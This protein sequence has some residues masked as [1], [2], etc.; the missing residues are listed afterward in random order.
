MTPPL[1]TT[2]LDGLSVRARAIWVG[3]ALVLIVMASLSVSG[4]KTSSQ[5]ILGRGFPDH[6]LYRDINA[7]VGAGKPYYEAVAGEHRKHRYPLKPVFAVRQPTLA[8]VAGH[9]GPFAMQIGMIALIFGA[10]MAW[11]V[12]LEASLR[13]PLAATMSLGIA[14]STA[15]FVVD[16]VI[17]FHESWA[18]IL[19]ALAIAAWRPDRAGWSIGL[20][21]VAALVR[22]TAVP[23]LG[24]MIALSALGRRWIESGKWLG[25]LCVWAV[26]YWFHM[27]AVVALALPNDLVSP[28]WSGLGGWPRLVVMAQLASALTVTTPPVASALI[29]LSVLGWLSWKAE[30]GLIVAGWLT[31]MAVFV[32]LFARPDVFYWVVLLVPLQLVGLIFVPFAVAAAFGWPVMRR[33]ATQQAL[34]C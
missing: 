19:V 28:G 31:G 3:I 2:R 32:M 4:V 14:A 22:E 16:T 9:L 27:Q 15:S 6:Q 25:A 20:A 1:V 7:T 26:F 21:L 34:P 30:T 8:T 10:A 17:V 11:F 29:V 23:F 12:R 13:L 24:L 5:V 33:R 18:A